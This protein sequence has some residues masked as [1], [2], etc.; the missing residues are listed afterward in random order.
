VEIDPR[1]MR[2][3][4]VDFLLGDPSKAK[5]LLGWQPQVKFNELVRMMV[6]GDMELARQESTL[7]KAGHMTPARASAGF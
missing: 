4:E 5:R 1:Y 3:T 2:P 7:I 6:D